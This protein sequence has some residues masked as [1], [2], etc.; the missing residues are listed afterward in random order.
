MR[1]TKPTPSQEVNKMKLNNWN[2]NSALVRL[3][4]DEVEDANLHKA[5]LLGTLDLGDQAENDEMRTVYWT[6]VRNMGKGIEGFPSF[7]G[8][9]S[10]NY[11]PEQE[12]NIHAV[13]NVVKN[14]YASI[15]TEMHAVLLKVKI[16]RATKNSPGEY[17]DWDMLVEDEVRKAQNVM[18][19]AF[20][21]K[22]WDALAM[23][24]N[25]PQ[26][27]PKA[28]KADTSEVSEEE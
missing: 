17:T 28:G 27:A 6:A 11:T 15:P 19:T 24:G 10:E 21:E 14:A 25:V 2:R 20:K 7:S 12:A 16:P 4:L 22:R 13:V 18:K 8:R 26:I 9:P 3:F 1:Q 23:D 5:T